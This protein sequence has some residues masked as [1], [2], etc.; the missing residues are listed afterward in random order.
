MIIEKVSGVVHGIEQEI[1][2]GKASFSIGVTDVAARYSQVKGI[3]AYN[4]DLFIIAGQPR[5]FTIRDSIKPH[6][7][8]VHIIN[9]VTSMSSTPSTMDDFAGES[10]Q[11]TSILQKDDSVIDIST[12]A[13]YLDY[14]NTKNNNTTL[15]NA[16]E[17]L[18]YPVIDGKMGLLPGRT[19][20]I[21][22]TVSFV[23][24]DK[25]ERLKEADLCISI[26]DYE[27]HVSGVCITQTPVDMS[28]S[29]CSSVAI[30]SG[31]FT[32]PNTVPDEGA[33]F[34]LGG[35]RRTTCHSSPSTA[36]GYIVRK[37]THLIIT[38]TGSKID[39]KLFGPMSFYSATNGRYYDIM[40]ELTTHEFT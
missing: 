37:G 40:A 38:D 13:K 29:S 19:Y 6:T 14:V 35:V 1:K 27:A 25:L 24:E 21:S 2:E 33:V 15:F 17:S 22:A 9:P 28:D 39:K 5:S 32:V 26:G 23:L 10:D 4:N 18:T 7:V 3:S 11:S 8:I 34:Y 31:S 16:G 20:N 36:I 30:F 12:H